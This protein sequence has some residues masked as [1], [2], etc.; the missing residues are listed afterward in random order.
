MHWCFVVCAGVDVK[1]H[2]LQSTIVA[3][4]IVFSLVEKEVKELGLSVPVY[5]VLRKKSKINTE[6]FLHVVISYLFDKPFHNPDAL[7]S[8]N[9]TLHTARSGQST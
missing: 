3:L 6:N 2:I 7:A 9:A 8:L 5:L 1:L 4:Y